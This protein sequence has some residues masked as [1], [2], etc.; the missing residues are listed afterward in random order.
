MNN[1]PDMV[2]RNEAGFTSLK[3]QAHAVSRFCGTRHKKAAWHHIRAGANFLAMKTAV[4]HGETGGRCARS[5]A[6]QIPFPMR[7][8]W[9]L[10]LLVCAAY[11]LPGHAA[12]LYQ[13]SGAQGETVFTSHPSEYHGCKWVSGP[14]HSSPKPAAARPDEAKAVPASLVRTSSTPMQSSRPVQKEVKANP[15]VIQIT[16]LQAPSAPVVSALPSAQG[17]LPIAKPWPMA[18]MDALA[19]VWLPKLLEPSQPEPA[20]PARS[21]FVQPA[22]ASTKAPLSA[23]VDGASPAP[24]RGAVYRITRKDG[25]VEYTNIAARA[26]GANATT[27]FTYIITCYACN[28]RSR[29]D[30]NTVALHL[31]DYG[32]AIHAAAAKNGVSE[33]LL[34]AIIHAE[35]AFNPRALSYKGAQ[36]LMQLMPGTAA[37]MGVTDAFDATQNISGGAKY[38]AQLLRDFNGNAT[39]AAAAYNAGEGAVRKYNGVPPYDETQV[40]VKRVAILRDRYL[41]ALHPAALAAAGVQ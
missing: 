34:R 9:V 29:V 16:P 25:T 27:L 6:T 11:A 13:C 38:L 1:L 33:A 26:Q 5:V 10:A 20:A 30:W 23:S 3:P 19:T 2:Y 32:N 36:G 35:S 12:A 41:K 18:V 24:K 31:H 40:Y 22:S 39:L 7:A 15:A 17:V 8:V 37:D 14:R 28:L 21:S 4:N